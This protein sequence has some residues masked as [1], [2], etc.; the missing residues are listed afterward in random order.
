M[1]FAAFDGSSIHLANDRIS[2]ADAARQERAAAE[3]LRRLERQPGV[4]LADEVGMGKTFVALAVAVSVLLDRG[5][6]HPVVVMSPPSLREKWPKDWKVFDEKCLRGEAAGRFRAATAD[7]GIEFLKLLDDPPERR[8]H[9]IF[10]TH[11]ALNRAIGDGFAK[12]AVIKRAFKGRSSLRV[13]RDNF[14]RWAS[15]LLWMDWVERRAE[16]LLG[17]LLER[18]C[19]QWLRTIHRADPRLAEKVHDD[20]VPAHLVDVLDE[21]SSGEF[22]DLVDQLRRLPQRESA[23]LEERLSDVR[24][25]LAQALEAVWA[26]A[27]RRAQFTSPLLILDEAH[28]VKN[29]ATRLASLFAS[30]EAAQESSKFFDSA[31]PLGSK[32]D[33][34]LFLTATPFQL[35]HGEL[36]RVLDRFEGINWSGRHAPT[37]TRSEFKTEIGALSEVLDDAQASALRLDRTWGRLD[38]ESA[39]REGVNPAADPDTWWERV[40]AERQDGLIGEVEAQVRSTTEA[41]RKAEAALTPW[42]LRH[43]KPTHLPDAPGMSRREMRTGAAIAGRSPH[44]GLEIGPRVLLPFL[45]AGRAQ[46]LLAS[47]AKGRALF[48]EGLASSFEAYLETRSGSDSLD[49]DADAAGASA[50]VELEWYLSHLD[51]ALPRDSQEIRSAHPKISA[52]AERAVDLWRGGEKVLIF[53]HYRATGRALRQHVSN[54]LNEEIFKLAAQ[55]LPELDRTRIAER[56]D[57]LGERFFK[58]E[59]LK[60]LVADWTRGIASEF[61]GLDERHVG[62]ITEV[63]R[64]FVRTPSFLVRYL[65]LGS[66]D[67]EAA[68]KG[69][70]DVEA[71]GR[72]SLRRNVAA[73]CRFLAERCIESERED[74]LDALDKVQ[75]GTH[76]GKEVRA[77]FDPA[78]G[79]GSAADLL[80]NVRLANGEVRAETRR[81]LLLTFNTPL[82]PEILI[83][84]SV[85]AEGVDLHLNCRYVIHHDLCWN[86]STLEQ[87]S[88][89]VDRI[90]SKAERV[91]Q[92]IHLYLPYVAETQD[93]KMFRVVRDRERWFQIVMGETYEVDEAATDARAARIPL[94]ERVQKQLSMRLHP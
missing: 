8:K 17:D 38:P 54:L 40:R 6:A 56:L 18:P 10:L 21:M 32:F 65:P 36:I 61:R 42:V 78:E 16:R 72:E 27:M 88:G 71:D 62:K 13:Q 53:C 23:N 1:S 45:L 31:G 79:K 29:P 19:D 25:A 7:S 76:F 30:E 91:S 5:G 50:P 51:R 4:I 37:M 49:E 75:T 84:S 39:S 14:G 68:F 57:A 12:L 94:P 55:K 3:V 26:V 89:R 67:L 69:A 74:F 77:V 73:F 22:N 80:P 20:P 44:S 41:M 47:S 81:R 48:A 83:A 35:G 63:V 64:R 9:L 24:R 34:M 70:A 87:R 15:R 2:E 28:H 60:A 86:P 58:D 43:L 82:F 85:L 66:D 33:R 90:G 52:T 92:S 93:E 11:G 59:A 46:A